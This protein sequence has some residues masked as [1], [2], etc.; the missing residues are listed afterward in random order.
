MVRSNQAEFNFTC[1]CNTAEIS[2]DF[3]TVKTVRILKI[4]W[5]LQLPWKT[6]GQKSRLGIVDCMF[7][8]DERLHKKAIITVLQYISNYIEGS[9]TGTEWLSL[10]KLSEKF[11]K[12]KFENY[13]GSNIIVPD[14][15]WH[16]LGGYRLK[17]L[18][19]L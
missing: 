15:T 12:T 17:S 14:Y 11:V 3:Q 6:S 5:K 2:D 7:N 4:S 19:P 8:K 1:V 16:N 10:S 9:D 13:Y 18:V